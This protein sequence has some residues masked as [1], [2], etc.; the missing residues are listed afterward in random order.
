MTLTAHAC[1]AAAQPDSVFGSPQTMVERGVDDT[2]DATGALADALVKA[3]SGKGSAKAIEGAINAAARRF[4]TSKL[5]K[6]IRRELLQGSML[7]ALD[8]WFEVQ[9]DRQVAVE[10]FAQMHS[11][12][13]ALAGGIHDTHFS[14]R[15]LQD[16]IKKFLEKKPVTRDVFDQMEKAAQR[17]AFTVANAANEAMVK[18]IKRELIRQVAV[19]ADLREFGKH[20]AERFEAAG[21]TPA[22]PSHVETVFR[23]NVL[24]A[25]NGGRARQM[26]QPEVVNLRPFWESLGVGDGRQRDKHKRLNNVVLRA[27]DPFWLEA[28]PPY[29]YACRCRTRSLSL[30]QGAGRVQEGK[31][32][33]RFVPDEGFT[34]G[35]STVFEGEEV[36]SRKPA[37]DVTEQ[38]VQAPE[39]DQAPEPEQAP[40]EPRGRSQVQVPAEPAA[41]PSDA[42]PSS[43][44]RPR[45]QPKPAK[46]PT[47]RKRDK[48]A[49]Q[50]EID[51]IK[52][53]IGNLQRRRKPAPQSEFDKL[54]RRIEELL[55]ALAKAR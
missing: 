27:S 37:N 43:R 36:P 4:G 31:G 38:P 19:G 33:L 41:P 3:V 15:P 50:T 21:W 23:T 39:P 30:K 13:R 44:S 47:P 53:R 7:G 16:A 46:K 26:L 18:T 1:F 32:F 42:P 45:S 34:S 22:N 48:S 51:D 25:Y 5:E 52:R 28:Y 29:G 35:L 14:E 54:R 8:A 49:I 12:E 10:T 2:L 24:G 6:P 11:A 20:A 55:D 9:T 17:R 40:D